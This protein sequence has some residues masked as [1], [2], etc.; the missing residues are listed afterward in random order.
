MKVSKGGNFQ[1]PFGIHV[2]FIVWRLFTEQRPISKDTSFTLSLDLSFLLV[3]LPF[4]WTNGDHPFGGVSQNPPESGSSRNISVYL[5]GLSPKAV[6][7]S[8]V[9]GCN[10]GKINVDP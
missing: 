1:R 6:D 8:L 9:T 5:A 10:W 3:D 2:A 7:V 4:G